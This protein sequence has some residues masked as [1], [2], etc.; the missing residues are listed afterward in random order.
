MSLNP[1]RVR[2]T[3]P[4]L[5]GPTAPPERRD[6]LII[7]VGLASLLGGVAGGIL[8]TAIGFAYW[9]FSA[10]AGVIRSLLLTFS[11]YGL[12]TFV[13]GFTIGGL[14]FALKELEIM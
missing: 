13:L 5:E 11:R 4:D 1:F 8:I 9:L 14:Y 2:Q 6:E 7:R 10:D 12:F 3:T